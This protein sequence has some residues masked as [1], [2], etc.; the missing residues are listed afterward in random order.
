MSPCYNGPMNIIF[1]ELD[2]PIIKQAINEYNSEHPDSEIT[3][4]C[5]ESLEEACKRLVK[6]DYAALIAG[7]D[8]TTRDVVLACKNF[9]G[10]PED[11]KTFSSCFV[12]KNDSAK[13]RHLK[14]LILADAGVTKLPTEAQLYDIVLETYKTAQTILMDTPKIAMLS[15]STLGSA[16]DDSIDKITRVIKK[17]HS[18]HP[19]IIIDGEMQLDCAINPEI[20]HKKAPGSPVAGQAN[21]LIVPDL[22]SGNIL[23]KSFEQLG[24]YIAAGPILQGFKKPV[25]DLSRGS[26]VAD[27]KLVIETIAKLAKS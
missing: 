7:I 16:R 23:Y 17:I 1:P 24:G 25:S 15:F 13:A 2:N 3:T 8:Y 4:I 9:L 22:N 21:V 27:V 6:E 20:A 5:I 19:E 14:T 18:G 10:M 26:S 11:V 12:L